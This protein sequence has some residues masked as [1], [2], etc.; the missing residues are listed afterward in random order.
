MNFVLWTLLTIFVLTGSGEEIF[1][2][3][4]QPALPESVD[5][6]ASSEISR[7]YTLERIVFGKFNADGSADT[8]LVDT[9]LDISAR[10]ENRIRFSFASL[11]PGEI[12]KSGQSVALNGKLLSLDT[13]DIT[14]DGVDEIIAHWSDTASQE[15]ITVLTPDGIAE[16][17]FPQQTVL[18]DRKERVSLADLDGDKRQEIVV[19]SQKKSA[20]SEGIDKIIVYFY[21]DDQL[22]KE[23]YA[24]VPVPILGM[25]VADLNQDGKDEIITLRSVVQDKFKQAIWTINRN[26]DGTY[27]EKPLVKGNQMTL[28]PLPPA[29]ERLFYTSKS[30]SQ[31]RNFNIIS[32]VE[33]D[34]DVVYQ[35]DDFRLLP[36]G[37]ML[38]LAWGKF[39]PDGDYS[40][41]VITNETSIS[42]KWLT[43]Y[44]PYKSTEMVNHMLLFSIDSFYPNGDSAVARDLDSDGFDELIFVDSYGKVRVL[45]LTNLD[46][47][48][49]EIAIIQ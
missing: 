13:G 34:G 20:Q 11:K 45:H 39:S 27:A 32:C 4:E 47:E 29:E 28:L 36:E 14:G 30:T 1:R 46:H 19:S 15:W 3:D 26:D 12:V 43:I 2:L 6:L 7:S 44:T 9:F 49:T 16:N 40:L 10:S 23:S 41:A 42:R 25:T 18:S 24:I 31:D 22:R 37:L 8:L 48:Q 38:D 17:I 33:T 5:L 21:L 35:S